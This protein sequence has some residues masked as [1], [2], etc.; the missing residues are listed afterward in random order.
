MNNWYEIK[1]ENNNTATIYIYDVIGGWGINANQ[2]IND[3][4]AQNAKD[5]TLRINSPGGNV[6]QALAIYH[7]LKNSQIKSTAIIE[8]LAA[9]AA[10]II[11]LGAGKLQM[12]ENSL[13]MIHNP[14]MNYMMMAAAE[15]EELRELSEEMKKDA[16]FLDKVKDQLVGVYQK[17]TKQSTKKITAWM[18]DETWFDAAEALEA[19]FVD[20]IT[21]NIKI[22]AKVD[23][24]GLKKS[25]FKNIP[26]NK[27]N[28]LNQ[29]NNK[30]DLQKEFQNLKSWVEAKIEG[31][32]TTENKE[33]KEIKLL[34]DEEVKK[35]LNGF[36]QKVTAFEQK[37]KDLNNIISEKDLKITKLENEIEVL[38]KEVPA[39]SLPV[40]QGAGAGSEEN[41]ID[42]IKSIRQN[43]IKNVNK[44]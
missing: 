24:D 23:I 43:A 11:A 6:F 22:A 2:L 19:G 28:L 35:M 42:S 37:E 12:A 5:V 27:I 17:K 18:T 41:I 21:D 8:G 13:F 26:E 30:M 33:V 38:K 29:I 7:F 34:D 9:S 1:N 36:S 44:Y 40:G 31:L 14:F 16:D 20:E 15:A 4:K 32:L 3:I 39:K 25:G 10:T